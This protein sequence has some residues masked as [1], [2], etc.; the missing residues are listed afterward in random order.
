MYMLRL[1]LGK[2]RESVHDISDYQ[3]LSLPSVVPVGTIWHSMNWPVQH[4]VTIVVQYCE[5]DQG[6]LV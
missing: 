2:T 3:G 5:Y 4:D 6:P 1:M